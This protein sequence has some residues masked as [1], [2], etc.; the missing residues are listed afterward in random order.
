M[1]SIQPSVNCFFFWFIEVNTIY[2]LKGN[3]L[4]Y[5]GAWNQR[6]A[7]NCVITTFSCEKS[8]IFLTS[9]KYMLAESK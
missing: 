5:I 9:R 8:M 1:H 4:A 3:H 2:V 6:L 7:S